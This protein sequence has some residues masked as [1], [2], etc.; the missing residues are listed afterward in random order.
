MKTNTD[1]NH[2]RISCWI[3]VYLVRVLTG[4]I[5]VQLLHY[6]LWNY[7]C[8]L[9]CA[10][11]KNQLPPKTKKLTEVSHTNYSRVGRFFMYKLWHICKT[12]GELR[13][14]SKFCSAPLEKFK[15]KSFY[16]PL[17]WKALG[18]S[19]PPFGRLRVSISGVAAPATTIKYRANVTNFGQ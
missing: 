12:V 13:E 5:C 2:C 11:C 17:T 3:A 16:T 8:C 7:G 18:R 15:I 4:Y 1:S 6:L 10:C 9:C 19:R 14:L